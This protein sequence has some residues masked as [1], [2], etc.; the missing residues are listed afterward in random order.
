MVKAVIDTNVI[1]SGLISPR[2][3]PCRILKAWES[4]RFFLCTSSEIVEEIARVLRYSK[5]RSK[6]HVKQTDI[7]NVLLSLRQDTEFVKNPPTVKTEGIPSNDIKFF[8]CGLACRSDFIVTGD[9][10]LLHKKSFHDIRVVSPR[11]FLDILD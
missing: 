8:A 4:E 5:I 11:V 1:V 3:T 9:K 2:G 6:Y 7:E 10:C